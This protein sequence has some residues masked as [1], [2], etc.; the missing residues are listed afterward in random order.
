MSG[1]SVD[2]LDIALCRFGNKNGQLFW[3]IINTETQPYSEN[4]TNKLLT[5]HKLHGEELAIL[6]FEYGKLLGKMVNRF[7]ES[8]KIYRKT[9]DAISSHGHTVFHQPQKGMTLQIGHGAALAGE[10]KIPV[11]CDFRS[12]DVA[13]GGHGAPLVPIGDRLL[14]GEYDFCLN[15]GGIANISFETENSRVAWDICPAN[16]VLNFL[17]QKVGES[18]DRDGK[19]AASGQIDKRLYNTLNQLDYYTQKP[20]K[21]LG[22][23]WVESQIFPLL[24]NSSLPLKD[25]MATFVEHIAFQISD[26]VQNHRGKRLLITGG[27]ARNKYLTER[28][29]KTSGLSVV[30]PN[31]VVIDYKEALIFALLGYLKIC[32]RINI[33]SSVTG[34]NH[35]H[36]SGIEYK[37]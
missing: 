18:F 1:T 7:I 37:I 11:I 4:W 9:I 8:N 13:L 33:F 36:V 28:I 26:T 2:G 6:H 30:L 3:E 29:N 27:G 14:F 25:Q 34:A 31:T 20:P 35:D 17:S 32:N 19:I 24:E 10:C 21:T 16:M 15:I 22:R 23:E 5:A 12:Q